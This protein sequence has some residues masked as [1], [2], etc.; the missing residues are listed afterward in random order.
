MEE[1]IPDLTRVL[2]VYQQ[3]VDARNALLSELHLK[4][5]RDPLSEFSEWLVAA[6]VKG[7]LA[8]S[9]VQKGWDVLAPGDIKIQVKYLANPA[10]QWINEHEIQ[11]TELMNFYAIVFFEALLPKSVII[12][13]A[14]NLAAVGRAL[15]KRHGKLVTY[16]SFT[17]ANY[18][19]I[20]NNVSLFKTLDVSVYVAPH[21]ALQN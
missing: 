8:E 3:Y 6:L 15:N 7:K 10:D 18:R 4:S 17:R 13:P 14:H 2:S 12:F 1:S 20:L 11:I 16:L 9:R 5:N 21:W 19:Q